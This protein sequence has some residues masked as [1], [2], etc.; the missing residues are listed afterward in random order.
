[1]EKGNKLLCKVDAKF[2]SQNY[3]INGRIY[4]GSWYTIDSI[5]KFGG[6]YVSINFIEHNAGV[7]AG[8][9]HYFSVYE[10]EKY[11]YTIKE[12]RKRKLERLKNESR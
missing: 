4:A 7:Y 9:Q 10:T 1:M 3:S 11:F 12:L 6:I 8:L 2:E 5:N